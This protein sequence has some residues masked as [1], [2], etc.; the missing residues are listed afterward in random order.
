MPY[1]SQTENEAA[2]VDVRFYLKKETEEWTD[3]DGNI[4]ETYTSY[5][6]DYIKRKKIKGVDED[7]LDALGESFFQMD[8]YQEFF[9]TEVPH[10]LYA[11]TPRSF[12]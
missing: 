12:K 4:E 7:D 9:A 6:I 1:Q 8:S 3:E 10:T 5:D 11:G 2:Y